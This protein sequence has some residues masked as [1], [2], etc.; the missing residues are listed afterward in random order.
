MMKKHRG[1]IKCTLEDAE[2]KAAIIG[3]AKL[4]HKER[5]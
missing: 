1:V 4:M 3:E 2:G 5:F